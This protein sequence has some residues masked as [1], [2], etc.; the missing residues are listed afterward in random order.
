MNGNLHHATITL[1]RSYRASV[2]RVFS[3]VADPVASA[4][5]RAPSEDV[6]IY[7]EA[8]FR[9]GRKDPLSPDCSKRAHYF[10]QNARLGRSASR[11]FAHHTRVHWKDFSI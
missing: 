6:L 8:D 7:D 5:S 11:R 9:I 4:R 1:K 10:K 3:Q 2:E